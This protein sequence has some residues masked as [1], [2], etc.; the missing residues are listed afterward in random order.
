[1]GGLGGGGEGKG[2]GGR[3]WSPGRGCGLGQSERRRAK[4]KQLLLIGAAG[5]GA[6]CPG[7]DA[8]GCGE[9]SGG[10]SDRPLELPAAGA[11]V[12]T[13]ASVPAHLPFRATHSPGGAFRVRPPQRDVVK[14]PRTPF[15][16]FPTCTP[17]MV[18]DGRYSKLQEVGQWMAADVPSPPPLT[19]R[20]LAGRATHFLLF[21]EVKQ[22]GHASLR[23]ISSVVFSHVL[24]R[25]EIRRG[26]LLNFQKLKML[27]MLVNAKI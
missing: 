24:L 26:C 13:H 15:P 9:R 23:S 4:Q 20:N 1:M 25:S 5:E 7:R 2:G 3:R 27:D 17:R 14:C 8:R 10:Q 19:P 12:H 11:P 21:S 22:Q 16:L 18:S 6:R